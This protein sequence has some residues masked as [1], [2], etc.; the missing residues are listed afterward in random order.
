MGSSP[1]NTYKNLYQYLQK[2]FRSGVV[3]LPDDREVL[4]QLIYSALLENR[5]A[6]PALEA[7][8]TIENSFIDW[9][10]LRVSTAGEL[11]DLLTML[12]DP[13]NSCER[14]RQTLQII[15]QS[16]YKFD[17]EEWR[18]KGEE[19]FGDYLDT[20]PFV[21]PF[22]KS[23]TLA[24][25]FRTGAVPLDEGA[26][27]VLRLLD[28]VEVDEENREVPIGLDRAFSKSNTLVFAKMLHELG[29]MLM[30]E[31]TSAR[32]RKI[33][34]AVDPASTQRSDI[35]LVE[36]EESDP[37]VIARELASRHQAAPMKM[38]FDADI[39]DAE[40]EEEEVFSAEDDSLEEPLPSDDADD[41]GREIPD[42][43][44]PETPKKRE[45]KKPKAEK[46][47]EVKA[48]VKAKKPAE[49]KAPAKAKKPAAVKAPAKEKKPAEAKAPA[50]AKKPA[51]VKAPVKAKKPAEVKAPVKAKKPAEAKAPAKAKKPAEVKAPA[52]AKKP[53]EVKAPAKAKKPAEVK[54]P[55]KAKKPAAVKAP[56]KAKKPAAV[57]APAKAKKPASKPASK[58]AAKAPVQK[59]LF[60]KGNAKKKSGGKKK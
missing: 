43:E 13:R 52:K 14:L 29:A 49:A 37:F 26:L 54:A 24:A 40:D 10:E 19:A 7:F 45:E 39:D 32:A 9:N 55:A 30:D 60:V 57:K 17:L 1:R 23:Y 51:E 22:M 20:I 50:K 33:I 25:V 41:A 48:P 27:R 56:A 46:P 8:E 4:V 36:I 6:A 11:C 58:P 35:P 2:E 44:E 42:F 59:T 12:K 38:N 34:K 3:S 53:A 18:E 31:T 28:L 47:A 21:T 15:F 16:T 5:P